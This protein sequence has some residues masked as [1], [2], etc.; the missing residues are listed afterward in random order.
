ME[1]VIE[2]V[3]LDDTIRKEILLK[4]VN[5]SFSEEELKADFK[6]WYV[7]NHYDFFKS[8]MLGKPSSNLIIVTYSPKEIPMACGNC[9]WHGLKCKDEDNKFCKNCA[10][11]KSEFTEWEHGTDE[12]KLNLISKI[13][14]DKNVADKEFRY[15]CEIMEPT[16]TDR[17]MNEIMMEDIMME[18][19]QENYY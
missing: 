9:A 12:D 13:R 2:N 17:E 5:T 10:P 4:V 16:Y 19:F 8:K 14:H 3:L 7:G 1:K 6:K 11:E 15:L 18:E